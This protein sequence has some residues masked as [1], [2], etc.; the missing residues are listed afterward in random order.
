MHA[1]YNLSYR[2]MSIIVASSF[3]ETNSVTFRIAL[4]QFLLFEFLP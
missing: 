3:T 1:R 2:D 4:F